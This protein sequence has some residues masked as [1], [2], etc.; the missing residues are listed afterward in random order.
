ME[1]KKPTQANQILLWLKRG[2]SITPLE[3]LNKFGSF[4][5][6]ARIYELK[7]RGY[8]IERKFVI[9]NSKK[10][11]AEYRLEEKWL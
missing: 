3:A 8:N 10:Y 9:T 6:G 7:K 11:V 5:L 4:R 2:H 1:N